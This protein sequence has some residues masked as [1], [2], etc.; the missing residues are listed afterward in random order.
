MVSAMLSEGIRKLDEKT[1]CFCGVQL[2]NLKVGEK[3]WTVSE[4]TSEDNVQ[5]PTKRSLFPRRFLSARKFSYSI[6]VIEL[7]GLCALELV[8]SLPVEM[9]RRQSG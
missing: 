3:R 5:E 9:N 6:S 7:K 1:V 2:V 8:L 4:I